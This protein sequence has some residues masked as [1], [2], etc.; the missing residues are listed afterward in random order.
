MIVNNKNRGNQN[1]KK[2]FQFYMKT[3][4]EALFYKE[5]IREMQVLILL[6]LDMDIGN[7]FL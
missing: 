5:K 3:L 6:V 1:Y 7:H 2:D 4:M